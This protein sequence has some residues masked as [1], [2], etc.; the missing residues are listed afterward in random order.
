MPSQRYKTIEEI[1]AAFTKL[2][3]DANPRS[4]QAIL[5]IGSEQ[6]AERGKLGFFRNIAFAA[7]ILTVALMI[8]VP[9]VPV[10]IRGTLAVWEYVL[11]GVCVVCVGFLWRIRNQLDQFLAEEQ[12]IKHLVVMHAQK[13]VGVPGFTP[14]PISGDLKV[15]LRDAMRHEKVAPELAA[16]ID[17]H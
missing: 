9:F 5:R 3:N 13:I 4:L 15:M 10:K 1:E 2:S 8:A 11:A 14:T 16:I 6:L 12:T 17:V 7:G